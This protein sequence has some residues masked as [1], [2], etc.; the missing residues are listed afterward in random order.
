M[1]RLF[2]LVLCFATLLGASSAVAEVHV[3]PRHLMILREGLDTVLGSYVFAVVNDGQA[4]APLKAQIVLPKEANDWAP[5]EGVEAESVKLAEGGGGLVIEKEFPPGTHVITIGFKVP[6]TLGHVQL[7]LKPAS[8]IGEMT[9]LKSRASKVGLESTWLKPGDAGATPDPEYDAYTADG[10]LVA[11]TEKTITIT[12]IPEGR[13]RY[14]LLGGG[15]AALLVLG[16]LAL[17]LKTRP[18]LAGDGAEA[19]LVG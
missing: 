3:S 13:A 18:R 16:A 10:P 5:Q 12:G 1:K 9:V 17:T 8:T 19:V 14:W 2:R 4:P 6:V 7:T 15:V 11:G